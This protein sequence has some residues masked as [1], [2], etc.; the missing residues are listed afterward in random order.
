MLHLID[1]LL[2]AVIAAAFVGAVLYR[3]RHRGCCGSGG[4]CC[5]NCAG[6]AAACGH[7]GRPEPK[8]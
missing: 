7:R 5:G 1:Y 8:Q 3:R 4:G 2:I 6:C